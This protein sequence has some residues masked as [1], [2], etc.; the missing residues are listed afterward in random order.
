M[1]TVIIRPSADDSKVTILN[2]SGNTNNLYSY[3]DEETLDTGDYIYSPSGGFSTIYAQFEWTSSGLTD[4]TI[5]SIKIWINAGNNVW[6]FYLEDNANQGD[7]NTSE[8]SNYYSLT[9]TTNPLTSNAWTV[10]EIE[11]LLA[12]VN[13]FQSFKSTYRLYQMY[14]VVDYT[15]A[16]EATANFFPFFEF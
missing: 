8:G 2:S 11:N 10:N 14:I 3:V 16:E 6:D 4:E 13:C 7:I 9:L 1:A 12:G 15:E 5:N